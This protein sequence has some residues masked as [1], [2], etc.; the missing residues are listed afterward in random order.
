MPQGRGQGLEIVLK[1]SLK[2][3]EQDKN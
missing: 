2:D 1:E 3:K